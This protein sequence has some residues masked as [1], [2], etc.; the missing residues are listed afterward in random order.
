MNIAS[1]PCRCGQS[2][3]APASWADS[4]STASGSSGASVL[5]AYVAPPGQHRLDHARRLRDHGRAGR[6]DDHAARP[7]RVDGTV[8]QGAL[9]GDQV[10]EVLGPPPPPA[11]RPTAQ[12]TQPGAR[13]VDQDPVER[14]IGPGGPRPVAG[15]HVTHR[16]SHCPGDQPRP[17]QLALVGQ[18]PR[19]LLG[20]ESR[21]E[22]GLPAGSGAQVEPAL[23]ASLDGG[24]RQGQCDQ[25]RAGVLHP[26]A[27]LSHRRDRTRVARLEHHGERRDGGGAGRHPG[28]RQL[29][30]RRQPRAS[31][32]RHERALVVGGEQRVEL[33]GPAER[34]VEL[35]H[36]PL[37][38]GAAHCSRGAEV[39]PS[40]RRGRAR[41]S[42]ASGRW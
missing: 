9:Q 36:D 33:L 3:T 42:A 39:G 23:V 34:A 30:H 14:V 29:R 1:V 28:R 37:R 21:E 31:H 16:G 5:H 7:H 10:L 15:H 22:C 27:S 20:G 6:V 11:L 35:L 2:W 18:Q 17:V 41:R 25:L 12:G 4:A 38:V 19:T 26:G 24:S 32:E 13:R 40:T 8:Q